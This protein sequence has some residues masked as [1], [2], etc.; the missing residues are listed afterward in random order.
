V[1]FVSERGFTAAGGDRG[2]FLVVFVLAVF[3]FGGPAPAITGGRWRRSDAITM[4]EK[5]ALI[6]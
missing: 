4:W 3:G 1:L 5:E 6:P 2:C